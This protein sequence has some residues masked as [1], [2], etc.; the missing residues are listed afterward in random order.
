MPRAE[1]Q[2]GGEDAACLVRLPRE[3]LGTRDVDGRSIGVVQI[4]LT[5]NNAAVAGRPGDPPE[6]MRALAIHGKADLDDHLDRGRALGDASVLDGLERDGHRQLRR[7]RLQ[8]DWV[9]KL[10]LHAGRDRRR[11][12]RFLLCALCVAKQYQLYR[13][14]RDASMVYNEITGMI[15]YGQNLRDILLEKKIVR[16][17]HLSGIKE[18]MDK[19]GVD[20]LDRDNAYKLLRVPHTAHLDHAKAVRALDALDKAG[21][22]HPH[23]S[24]NPRFLLARA[25]SLISAKERMQQ[26]RQE[27]TQHEE[28]Q[29][30]IQEREAEAQKKQKTAAAEISSMSAA[31]PRL[32]PVSL[33]PQVSVPKIVEAQRRSRPMAG[34]ATQPMNTTMRPTGSSMPRMGSLKLTRTPPPQAN[35]GSLKNLRLPK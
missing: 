3:H 11:H 33:A 25:T 28:A 12:S 23:Y 19:A 22:V 8:W 10:M 16:R 35:L 24:G 2:R 5:H 32:K 15:N 30:R 17:G 1:S 34:Q 26:M 18:K 21:M 20:K 6:P 27:R 7:E 14:A 4:N 13:L 9:A 29:R 31:V